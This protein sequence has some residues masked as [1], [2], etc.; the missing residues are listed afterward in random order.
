MLV[1]DQV[2][3]GD[4]FSFLEGVAKQHHEGVFDLAFADPPYNLAKNY[5]AYDD[6]LAD[7]HY[8]E[9][10]NRWLDGMA[11]TLKPG[12]SLFVLNLP[13]WAMHHATF[14]NSRLDFRHWIVWDALSDPRGIEVLRR[15][16]AHE[17][18]RRAILVEGGDRVR[19]PGVDLQHG[20]FARRSGEHLFGG[21]LHAPGEGGQVFGSERQTGCHGMTAEAV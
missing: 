11:R 16:A 7:Q 3:L 14:L 4:C 10:C 19:Q 5:D 6:A 21:L 12:G 15:A 8:L 18:H 13:K 9:W 1:R 17:L 2:H 20:F